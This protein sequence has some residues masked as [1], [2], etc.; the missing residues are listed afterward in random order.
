MDA[1]QFL[2]AF[3]AQDLAYEEAS[4]EPTP[5]T[6]SKVSATHFQELPDA[7][8]TTTWTKVLSHCDHYQ[9][10]AVKMF[11]VSS[12]DGFY[13]QRALGTKQRTLLLI[14]VI[15]NRVA[16]LQYRSLGKTTFD[17]DLTCV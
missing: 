11:Q 10:M 12:A 13:A 8:W 1:W 16:H 7:A 5:L 6:C 9:G 2:A 4:D 3:F 17:L 15:F 14:I